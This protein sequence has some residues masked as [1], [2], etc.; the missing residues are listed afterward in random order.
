MGECTCVRECVCLNVCF[1]ALPGQA[2][3]SQ[4]CA[5]KRRQ[6]PAGSIS[7]LAAINLAAFTHTHTHAH[8]HTR[9][10][11]RVL[12]ST[13]QQLHAI[14]LI[15]FASLFLLHTSHNCNRSNKKKKNTFY[16][17]NTLYSIFASRPSPHST[18]R[19]HGR[20]VN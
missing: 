7:T 11:F 5:P 20:A 19:P 8:T 18:P 16:L 2:T 14:L 15:F 10:H 3:S 12:A 1:Q 4:G 9:T 6:T 17:K 13:C